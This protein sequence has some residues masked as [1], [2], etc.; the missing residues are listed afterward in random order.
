MGVPPQMLAGSVSAVT[1]QRL[2]RL[3]CRI[4]R[5]PGEAPAPQTLAAHGIA[6]DEAAR[7]KFF[8]GRGCPTCNKVGYRGRRAIFEV[9]N[10][11]PEIR[12]AVQ[13]GLSAAEIESMAIG[14]G[15]TTL[16]ARCLQLVAEGITT[17]DEFAKLRL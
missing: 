17:F 3:I 12:T 10:G 11:A 13:S 7:L 4:C 15:M 16:R 5:E 2:V 1:C 9:M 6:P 14:A 8:R